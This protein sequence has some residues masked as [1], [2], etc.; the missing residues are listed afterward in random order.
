MTAGLEANKYSN[1][2]WAIASW[3]LSLFFFPRFLF[4]RRVL[5]V[6]RSWGAFLHPALQI[7]AGLCNLGCLVV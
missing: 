2:A 7:L 6:F 3:S 1:R 4:L 5:L